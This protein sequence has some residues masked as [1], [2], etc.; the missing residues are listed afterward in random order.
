MKA[1]LKVG[2]ILIIILFLLSLL[3]YFIFGTSKYSEAMNN[4]IINYDLSGC[5]NLPSYKFM[6]QSHPSF[7]GNSYSIENQKENCLDQ[8]GNHFL[9]F[10]SDLPALFEAVKNNDPDLCPENDPNSMCLR[11][12]EKKYQ[13]PETCSNYLVESESLFSS[14]SGVFKCQGKLIALEKQN[15]SYCEQF[16]KDLRNIC[17]YF[18][19]S[20]YNSLRKFTP[21]ILVIH[22]TAEGVSYFRPKPLIPNICDDVQDSFLKSNCGSVFE[23]FNSWETPTIEIQD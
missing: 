2:I 22:Q 6:V 20:E 18:V 21:Q 23:E 12:I 14:Y 15:I 19:A 13:N 4:A 8:V 17:Y 16:D 9:I 1:W 7:L 5:K 3:V 11:T 10:E